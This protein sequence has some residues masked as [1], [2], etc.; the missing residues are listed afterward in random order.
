MGSG[1]RSKGRGTEARARALDSAC[2]EAPGVLSIID[3]P[4]SPSSMESE[5]FVG[6]WRQA[7]G[8]GQLLARP[9]TPPCELT[10]AGRE[11]RE[12]GD[13]REKKEAEG[14]EANLAVTPFAF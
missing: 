4:S 6:T 9:S 7:P 1:G 11:E 13:K 5:L 3:G 8:P 10:Y 2:P 14:R 12:K